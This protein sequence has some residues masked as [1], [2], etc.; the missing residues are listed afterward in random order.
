ME[1]RVFEAASR[2]AALAAMRAACGGSAT[3]VDE[4]E[5]G[6]RFRLTAICKDEPGDLGHMLTG[7]PTGATA[8]LAEW[9]CDFHRPSA[10]CQLRLKS[11]MNTQ[12]GTSGP[13]MVTAALDH[14]IR[15]A[16]MPRID[17]ARAST[18]PLTMAFVGMPGAGKTACCARVALAARLAKMRPQVMSVDKDRVAATAQLAGLIEPVGLKLT[19]DI[20][21]CGPPAFIDTTG[22]NPY[23]VTE[24]NDL[25]QLLKSLGAEP[26]WVLDAAS[27]AEDAAELAMLFQLLGIKKA[28]ITR[29]DLCRRLGSVLSIGTQ[30]MAIIGATISPL[31]AKPVL[32]MTALGLQ[33]L[34]L[35]HYAGQNSH[36]ADL[37]QRA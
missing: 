36:T 19:D 16:P 17:P 14:L 33:R 8:H 4:R 31:V 13:D 23:S 35:R 37:R 11:A 9:I 22:I 12:S 18:A 1:M 10:L 24:M 32:P 21:D 6:G 7:K 2:T 27:D 20:D 5:V 3:V 34:L 25:G 28:I 15:F 29:L 30:G 26:V